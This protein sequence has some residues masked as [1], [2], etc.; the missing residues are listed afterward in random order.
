MTNDWIINFSPEWSDVDKI[1]HLQRRVLVYATLYYEY[2][3][4]LPEWD[5]YQYDKLSQF[6]ARLM[7]EHTDAKDSRFYYVFY[8]FEGSTAYHLLS[9]LIE[10][11]RKLIT[12][13]ALTISRK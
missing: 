4:T 13:I 7:R 9:R 8:D 1:S 2:D 10:E 12:D 3:I 5:D 6:V 11:D